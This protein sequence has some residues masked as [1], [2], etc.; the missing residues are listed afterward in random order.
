MRKAE[1]YALQGCK[2]NTICE[3]MSWHENF[4]N[5]HRDILKRLTKKRAERKFKLRKQQ[6]RKAAG[7]SKAS[8]TMQIWLGKN[9]LDQADKIETKQTGQIPILI[10][11]GN[12][13][14]GRRAIGAIEGAKQLLGNCTENY[15]TMYKTGANSD[16]LDKVPA[17]IAEKQR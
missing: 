6:N 4:I 8:A 3:L 2:N 12:S 1:N 11:I 16:N 10:I 9:E 13:E 5:E 7:D 17:I 14:A 15:N